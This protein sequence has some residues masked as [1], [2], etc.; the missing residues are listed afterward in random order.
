[1][2]GGGDRSRGRIDGWTYRAPAGRALSG[3][4]GLAALSAGARL[5]GARSRVLWTCAVLPD[6]ALLYGIASA[7]TFDPLPRHAVLPYNLLH[8]VG[9]PALLYGTATLLRSRPLTVAALGWLAHIAI[10]HASGYG[11]RAPDGSRTLPL[12]LFR[13]A[14]R[15]TRHPAAGARA[16]SPAARR[17]PG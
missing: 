6:A 12:S 15:L 17:R 1:M 16:A 9:V 11:P 13:R 14:G 7:P 5:G 3:A 8:N 4:V 10:D 2:K